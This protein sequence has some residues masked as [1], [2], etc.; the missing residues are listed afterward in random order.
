MD[1][2]QAIFL[3]F[4]QGIFEWLPVSSQGNISAIALTLFNLSVEKASSYAIF[5]HMGTLFSAIIYFRREIKA[6]LKLENKPLLKF[7]IIAVIST[8]LTALPSYLF[9]KSLLTNAFILLLAIGIFLIITGLIQK[10]VRKSGQAVFSNKNAFFL[11]LGQG[12]SVLPGISRSGTTTSVL[13]FEGFEPEQAFRTS[14]LLSIPSVLIAEIIFNM[15]EPTIFD[16]NIITALVTAAI[17]GF[18]SIDLL[19]RLAKKI[20]FSLFCFLFGILYI[21][22]ALTNFI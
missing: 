13:L 21:I 8:A 16:L 3:G 14:F 5:L 9:L 6:L 10:F 19:I 22:I 12:F 7:L 2:I 15:F 4:L 11:G 17:T 20:R 18:L 1:L